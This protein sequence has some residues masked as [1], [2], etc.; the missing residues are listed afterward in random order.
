[1]PNSCA[2]CGHM[3]V[4][5]T[6]LRVL[7]GL[8]LVGVNA[9]FVAIEF[10][11]TRLPQLSPE[12]LR[13]E[14]GLDEALEMTER[15]E[16]HLTG[17]QLG[18]SLSSILLGVVAEP[19]VTALLAPLF[20]LLGLSE[21]TMSV[22]GV[23]VAIVLIQLV[24]KIW[25]EQAPTYLGVERPA[26]VA[27]LLAKPLKLWST[28]M[29][30]LIRMGDQL[31][32]WTL[33]LFGVEMTR[34]WVDKGEDGDESETP[35]AG[36]PEFRRQLV[37]VLADGRIGEERR[38][39]IVNAYEIG[40]QTAREIMVSRSD[41]VALCAD[42]PFERIMK[43]VRSHGFT[44]YPVVGESLD[45]FRGILYLPALVAHEESLVAGEASLEDICSEPLRVSADVEI[46]RL[47][48]T[49]QEHGEELAF[50]TEDDRVI[51]LVTATDAFEAIIG[52]LVDP[53]DTE[54]DQTSS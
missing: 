29:S 18:I 32:K 6:T 42:E 3:D 11:L 35:E 17:C 41:I 52:E 19:A 37:E 50:V 4:L 20:G 38:E 16:F 21:S 2:C 8:A 43:D 46:D 27:R 44:R 14:E 9:F 28:V 39:E 13:E 49:F 10:A 48:D 7:G 40:E 45:D 23:V 31:A 47:I 25:G 26:D 53:L 5:E 34:S 36:T 51:G 54:V 33:L 15:L 22:A 30:P 12:E 24:H 1:M